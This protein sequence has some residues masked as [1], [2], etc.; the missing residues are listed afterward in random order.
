KSAGAKPIV[1]DLKLTPVGSTLAFLTVTVKSIP[2]RTIMDITANPKFGDLGLDTAITGPVK[3]DWGGPAKN[4]A[5]T[6]QVEANLQLSPPGVVRKGAVN[7]VP[8]AGPG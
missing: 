7:N 6:V 2:L 1:K 8:G 5:D 3:V 4:I